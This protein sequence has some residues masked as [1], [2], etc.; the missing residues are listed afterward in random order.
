MDTYQQMSQLLPSSVL[1]LT[2]TFLDEYYKTDTTKAY[3]PDREE[4]S[5]I[6][7]QKHI[8]LL[9]GLTDQFGPN[10]LNH[11]SD[12]SYDYEGHSILEAIQTLPTK[13]RYKTE[14]KGVPPKAPIFSIDTCVARLYALH[15][16]VS[17]VLSQPDEIYPQFTNSVLLDRFSMMSREDPDYLDSLDKEIQDCLD[18][19]KQKRKDQIRSQEVFVLTPK[20]EKVYLPYLELSARIETYLTRYD[21]A[22]VTATLIRLRMVT[23]IKDVR[24]SIEI[25]QTC[26]L[27]IIYGLQTPMRLESVEIIQA[28]PSP[29]NLA[30]FDADLKNYIYKRNNHYYVKINDYKIVEEG[31]SEYVDPFPTRAVPYYNLLY[32]L[33]KRFNYKY[34]FRVNESSDKPQATL[35]LQ[36]AFEAATGLRL[37]VDVLRKIWVRYHW[38]EGLVH[39][40]KE[41]LV[42]FARSMRHNLTTHVNNYNV[43][44]PEDYTVPGIPAMLAV[45]HRR[46]QYKKHRFEHHILKLT[47]GTLW[48]RRPSNENWKKF[49][50]NED[51]VYEFEG[52]TGTIKQVFAKTTSVTFSALRNAILKELE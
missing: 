1:P 46:G 3:A 15:N 49:K 48:G 10:F 8:S 52:E 39:V 16:L 20:D 47:H 50:L 24:Q 44:I 34:L 35:R 22:W 14:K 36:D 40:T 45:V 41:S 30:A 32:Q 42:T 27:L 43:D 51:T 25:L 21:H 28:R 18:F 26:V 37:S 13:L 12:E 5:S 29:F 2:N 31:R 38:D 6:T 4:K 7:L 33:T 11:I 17:N 23:D 19:Q 9:H